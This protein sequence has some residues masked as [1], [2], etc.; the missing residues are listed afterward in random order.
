MLGGSG[1]PYFLVQIKTSDLPS[2]NLNPVRE[3][4]FC[5]LSKIS[6]KFLIVC[7][8]RVFTF[9]ENLQSSAKRDVCSSLG[10]ECLLQ[11]GIE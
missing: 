9:M 3:A 7:L 5:K 8:S 1:L 4:H 6:C 2:A 11:S 10:K